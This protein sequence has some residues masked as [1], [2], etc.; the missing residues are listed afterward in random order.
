M[1]ANPFFRLYYLARCHVVHPLKMRYIVGGSAIEK[2]VAIVNCVDDTLLCCCGK[3]SADV[4][5]V[6]QMV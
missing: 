3:I 4:V 1:H 6:A 5:D 2:S